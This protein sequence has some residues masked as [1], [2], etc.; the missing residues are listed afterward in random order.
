MT[1]SRMDKVAAN[2]RAQRVR[3][4]VTTIN[5]VLA[6][7]DEIQER[8]DWLTL[9]YKGWFDYIEAEF[10][11]DRLKLTNEERARVVGVLAAAPGISKRRLAKM[12]GVSEGTVRNDVRRSQVRKNYALPTAEPQ[13][14]ASDASENSPAGPAADSDRERDAGAHGEPGQ[15]GPAGD[16]LPSGSP[17]AESI[18]AGIP[19]P[20]RPVTTLCSGGPSQCGRC[21]EPLPT[22]EQSGGHLRCRECDPTS[23]HKSLLDDDGDFDGRCERCTRIAAY[24]ANE[25]SAGTHTAAE[26]DASPEGSSADGAEVDATTSDHAFRSDSAPA[27]V[28][29]GLPSSPVG[30]QTEERTEDAASVEESATCEKCRGAIDAEQADVGGYTRCD[31]CDPDGEHY[32]PMEGNARGRCKGC[33]P[34]DYP[35]DLDEE[36][37]ARLASDDSPAADSLAPPSPQQ[38]GHD[39]PPD[40]GSEGFPRRAETD[41]HGLA[42][43]SGRGVAPAPPIA[44]EP[45]L[46]DGG[47]LPSSSSSDQLMAAFSTLLLHLADA[48]AEAIGPLLHDDDVEQLLLCADNI[49]DFIARLI[50]AR[51]P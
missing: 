3:D 32:A 42:G 33:F 4:G 29:D 25:R 30:D 26:V 43:V 12:L 36:E 21:G 23:L 27:P 39:S 7:L 15:P 5:D 1:V 14:T 48:D 28:G 8:Q 18:G 47:N 51:T 49:Q 9:G 10:G 45:E 13:V 22:S 50:K 41:H 19:A 16:P 2:R 6:T 20:A 38:P 35:E 44:V 34:G 31:N 37:A 24:F 46:E 11:P 40:V 17:A